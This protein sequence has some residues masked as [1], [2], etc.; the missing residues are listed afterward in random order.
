MNFRNI[1][2]IGLTE[3]CF[4]RGSGNRGRKYDVAEGERCIS[5]LLGF[6][7]RRFLVDLW[8]HDGV[9]EETGRGW[10][11]L[12]PIYM[13]AEK[14][15]TNSSDVRREEVVC[16][17]PSQYLFVFDIFSDWLTQTF[18]DVNATVLMVVLNLH[19]GARSTASAGDATPISPTPLHQQYGLP[20]EELYTPT[21]LAEDRED[22]NITWLQGDSSYDDDETRYFDVV[23]RPEGKLSSK[24]AWPSESYLGLDIKKR[25]LLSFGEASVPGYDVSQDRD[26]IFK[27]EDTGYPYLISGP[28]KGN[29]L[30]EPGNLGLQKPNYSW[31][32]KIDTEQVPFTDNS[33]LALTECGI[34][35]VINTTRSSIKDYFELMKGT[36]WSWERGEP[37]NLSF[38]DDVNNPENM[39]RC[40]TLNKR[41]GR[42]KATKC[43]EKHLPA[44]RIANSPYNV[45]TNYYDTSTS[46][47]SKLFPSLTF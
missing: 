20:L 30:F 34:S 44:C 5:D 36:I 29:C 40:A 12:C 22:L 8:W 42:W 21:Q 2:G 27:T 39:F 1:P 24:T 46:W 28:S 32:A 16:T 47:P 3:T 13:N 14:E 4:S 6:G 43:H 18:Y 31:A 23:V 19:D 15:G 7:Y 41:S 33:T 10:W 38:I 25:L 37:S 35:M 17:M 26:F 11:S 45:G 9:A